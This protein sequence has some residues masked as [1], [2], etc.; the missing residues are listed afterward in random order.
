MVLDG[1]YRLVARIGAGG[2][3]EVWRGVDERMGR[4]VAVKLLL[5]VR[6]S[7]EADKR[8]EREAMLVGRLRS[9]AIVTVHDYGS[10]TVGGARMPYLVMELLSGFTLGEA[11]GADPARALAWAA[12][13]CDALGVAHRAGVV[14]RDVKPGNVMVDENGQVKVLDFGIARFV[15]EEQAASGLTATGMVIGTAQYMS[16]E[17]AEAGALDGRSDLYS[18][19]CVLYFLLTGRPPFLG[20]NFLRL[21]HQHVGAEPEPPSVHR[22]G[23]PAALDRLVLDL[24][25][26]NPTARP[27]DA[28]AVRAR[29]DAIRA[30]APTP[31]P[32]P[33]Q[34]PQTPLPQQSVQAAPTVSAP[35]RHQYPAPAQAQTPPGYNPS[36]GSAFGSTAQS[37]GAG[38]GTSRRAFLIGGAVVGVGVVG[39]GVTALA[40][41]L[42]NG[43]AGGGSAASTAVPRFVTRLE[44]TGTETLGLAPDGSFA[45]TALVDNYHHKFSQ[46]DMTDPAHPVETQ[47]GSDPDRQFALSLRADGKAMAVLP[48]GGGSSAQIWTIAGPRSATKAGAVQGP[49]E[50]VVFSPVGTILAADNG[51]QTVRLWD[52][53]DPAAATQKGILSGLPS[54][55]TDVV[56]SADGKTLAVIMES[57]QLPALHRG[58]PLQLW[59]VSDPTRPTLLGDV[60]SV[61]G[62]VQTLAFSP[63]GKTLAVAPLAPTNT[64]AQQPPGSVE[65]FDISVPAHPKAAGTIT[66]KGPVYALAYAPDGKTLASGTMQV[67][68][69]VELWDVSVPGTPKARMSYGL[70]NHEQGGQGSDSYDLVFTADGKRLYSTIFGVQ[71][72]QIAN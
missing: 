12:G 54:H 34:I 72:W 58:T 26:K 64:G 1:R 15:A 42:G 24:L 66:T 27:Q 9:P 18:L 44:G 51:D 38:S 8:F 40:T 43:S 60:S 36:Q 67:P 32:M 59:D 52:V 46:W 19:G 23:L 22:P 53:S 17:Q 48:T 55:V 31:M 2:M 63:D 56:F 20:D 33:M 69:Y 3:G 71:L 68:E 65:V 41:S 14:H 61:T 16:P 39:A 35:P 47:L 30:G 37:S 10:A 62:P 7:D 70:T 29:I 45:V 57:G 11:A 6:L 5:G 21:A 50:L 28:A 4:E 25:A 49:Q 13:V